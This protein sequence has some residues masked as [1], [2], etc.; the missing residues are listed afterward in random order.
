MYFI[1]TGCVSVHAYSCLNG[2]CTFE[3]GVEQP[4]YCIENRTSEHETTSHAVVSSF[5]FY[6]CLLDQETSR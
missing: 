5:V 2:G 6:H 4:V 1:G 3:W